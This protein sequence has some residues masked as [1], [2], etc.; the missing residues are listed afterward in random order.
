MGENE[1]GRLR[2]ESG[3]GARVCDW[4]LLWED[5]DDGEAVNGA[6]I[7]PLCYDV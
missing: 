6:Y 3:R 5:P 4:S 1:P 7:M 2:S